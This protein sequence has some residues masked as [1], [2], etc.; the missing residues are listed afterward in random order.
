MGATPAVRAS[1]VC[2]FA[3]TFLAPRCLRGQHGSTG[4]AVPMGLRH[5]VLLGDEINIYYTSELFG[6]FRMPDLQ[7]GNLGAEGCTNNLWESI[8]HESPAAKAF[9][10]LWATPAAA[11]GILVG[12]GDNFAP[13]LW[14]R[15]FDVENPPSDQ[16]RGL[17]A[18][19]ASQRVF[20]RTEKEL[21]VWDPRGKQWIT[22]ERVSEDEHYRWLLDRLVRG[23][24]TIPTDNVGCFLRHAGYA[25][26]VPG[27]YDFYFGPER[28]R[29]LAR[30]LASKEEFG[31]D[32]KTI[33]FKPVQMLG[34]NLVI[35]TAWKTDHKP[36]GDAEDPPWFIPR[37]PKVQDLVANPEPGLEIQLSGLSDGGS[38]YPWFMGPTVRLKP[39]TAQAQA[40]RQ[41]LTQSQ[42]YLCTAEKKKPAD[43]NPNGMPAS[44]NSCRPVD[45]ESDQGSADLSFR[46]QF[47]WLDS[48]HGPILDPNENYGLC[49]E[50]PPAQ[51]TDRGHGHRFCVRFSVYN[52][53]FRFPA[54]RA[55]EGCKHGKPACD[56]EDPKPYK[57]VET[58]GNRSLSKD[59]V[60]FGVVD[61]Q[62]GQNVGMLNFSWSNVEEQPC[63]KQVVLSE[64]CEQFLNKYAEDPEHLHKPKPPWDAFDAAGTEYKTETAVEDPAEALSETVGYFERKY[65]DEHG[66]KFD[67]VRVLLAQMTPQ[68][69]QV[70]ATR[71]GGFDVV[72]SDADP[73]LAGVEE[74]R[75]AKW[76]TDTDPANP[77]GHHAFLAVPEPYWVSDREPKEKV[78]LGH[79]TI[80]D[81]QNRGRKLT[82]KHEH[83]KHTTDPAAVKAP[84]DFW[85]GA[86]AYINNQ[87]QTQFYPTSEEPDDNLPDGDKQDI[88][89]SA[90]A[91]AMQKETG[92]DV[93]LL[94]A[95]D[96]YLDWEQRDSPAAFAA[97]QQFLDRVI[98]KGDFL[99]LLYVPGSTLQSVIKQSQAFKTDDNSQLSLSAE[100]NRWLLPNGVPFGVHQNPDSKEYLINEVPLDPTRV[101]AVATSDYIAAGD[102]GYP[103]LAAS[104]IHKFS[105][106]SDFDNPLRNI[107]AA[108][109]RQI[110]E[111]D[112]E[113]SGQGDHSIGN[114]SKDPKRDCMDDIKRDDYFDAIIASPADTRHGKTLG[115]QLWEWSMFD[116]G[117]HVP[118][119]TGEKPSSEGPSNLLEQSI[120]RRRLGS[121]RINQPDTT[122]FALDN[123][124][125]S[126]NVTNHRFSDATLANTFAG[127]PTPQLS[128]KRSHIIGYDI[129][130]KFL[131]SW[132]KYQLFETTEFRYDVQYVGNLNASRTINQLQNLFSSDSG[133]AWDLPNRTLPH[134]ELVGTFHYETQLVHPTVDTLAPLPK[135]DTLAPGANTSRAQYF[136]PRFGVRGVNRVSWFETGLEDGGEVDAVR[137]FPPPP[138]GTQFGLFRTDVRA[139][140]TYWKWHLVVPF[141]S[142]VSWTLDGNGDFFFG[143]TGDAATDTRFRSDTK[144][145]VNFQA[146]PSLT[147][148]P[149]Y[150]FFYYAN[151][152]KPEWFWQNQASIQMKVR[153]DFWNHHRL[154]DQFEY[155]A[156]SAGPQ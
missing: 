113:R 123:A 145:S 15:Q 118:G 85:R 92:A 109:C 90:T 134:V 47:R 136:L 150:E 103:D 128:A 65:E 12:T 86:L 141:G 40:L 84:V 3:L 133:F 97:F 42:F 27:K 63:T 124:A 131:Y 140:G 132:H 7:P 104:A 100:R 107:S 153:Y 58:K 116:P 45:V 5:W 130:P 74:T 143:Q 139:S 122:L 135:G 99:T 146:F 24:G 49:V 39:N 54:D 13:V 9:D 28:L 71:V 154:A 8:E 4:E 147:F 2:L 61:P 10:D 138:G 25:A 80:T 152:V 46:L 111:N 52:P 59:V 41:Q 148:A 64:T 37:F 57:L 72:V 11:G 102:T 105:T 127:N 82:A 29:E 67:G 70:L 55:A 76:Q 1:I 114:A 17:D 53:F 96:F 33:A 94:Q 44:L 142:K 26:I 144:T 129:Q 79:I 43:R 20:N 75:T 73:Q 62:L 66:Q 112:K 23:V 98:W 31:P 110:E 19:G 30:F 115:P 22:N 36:V 101:Y 106:P 81:D 88:V 137:V 51:V 68:E 16:Y 50:V 32:G 35:E 14:A 48:G 117:K 108:V 155:R 156:A 119:S 21:F 38:V 151:K 89:E 121:T 78:Y 69:A 95:H 149:T 120:E 60:I 91:C 93:V 83:E 6:Y 34:A 77:Q 87:C 125:L 126:L 56:Y 18:H